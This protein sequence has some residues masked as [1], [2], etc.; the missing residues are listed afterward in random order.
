M[1]CPKCKSDRTVS[2]RESTY[3]DQYRCQD[4]NTLFSPEQSLR[5]EISELQAH[6]AKM[7]WQRFKLVRLLTAR[8]ICHAQ[9][10]CVDAFFARPCE[11]KHYNGCVQ[12]LLEWAEEVRE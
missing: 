2:T 3:L 6:V 1:K 4:C 7:E 9:D 10:N 5:A 8:S 11:R 12:C